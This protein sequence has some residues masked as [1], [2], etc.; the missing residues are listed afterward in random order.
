M[1]R[2]QIC[3][4]ELALGDSPAVTF[5]FAN[6]NSVVVRPDDFP[7]AMQ[8][9]FLL[10]GISQKL[11]DAYAGSDSADEAQ[12]HFADTI[13]KVREGNWTAPSAGAGKTGQARTDLAHALMR[14]M[15]QSGQEVTEEQCFQ[16]IDD[17]ESDQV[18]A[19]RKDASV[20]AA[21]SMIRAERLQEKAA[22]K[23][24]DFAALAAGEVPAESE[25]ED[26]DEGEEETEVAEQ[27][28]A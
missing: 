7:E 11:G 5:N 4:K 2:G 21:L 9:H 15:Q 19:L 26:E 13:E 28:A 6:G 18:K 1:A 25:D 10:Y 27:P 23:S 17:L 8:Q 3:K 14:V 12:K 16:V 24:L 20:K 22:G